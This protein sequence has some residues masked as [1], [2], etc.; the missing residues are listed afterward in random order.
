MLTS[1]GGYGD[2]LVQPRTLAASTAGRDIRRP[3][4][5]FLK[6]APSDTA[7]PFDDGHRYSAP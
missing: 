3:G 5:R 2:V 7:S 4:R 1:C 6:P